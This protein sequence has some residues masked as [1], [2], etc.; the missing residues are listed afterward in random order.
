MGTREDL[1][2][3]NLDDLMASLGCGA[4]VAPFLRRLFHRPAQVFADHMLAFDDAVARAGEL[5]TPARSLLHTHYV[6]GIATCGGQYIPTRGPALFLANHPG[7]TDALSLMAAIGRPDLKIIA[8]RRPFLEA[9]P[10]VA[11]RLF[12]VDAN[13]GRRVIVAHE[14]AQ[15]LNEGGAVLTF[16]AGCIEPDPDIAADAER[17]LGAWGDSARL[18]TRMAPHTQIVPTLV[19]GVTWQKV[20]QHWLTRLKR[21]PGARE[22]RAAALQLLAMIALDMKPTSVS[23]HF[24]PALRA[25]GDR[26]TVAARM[27][28]LISASATPVTTGEPALPAWP[29]APQPSTG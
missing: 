1:I 29:P 8:A 14:V 23:V 11:Q 28:Q 7:M 15:H 9:L 19:R 13:L 6:R 25:P 4:V 26:D 24:A 20:A 21:E 22:K 27:R 5:V 3:L 2:R 12:F 16:P 17:S 10:H 18:I